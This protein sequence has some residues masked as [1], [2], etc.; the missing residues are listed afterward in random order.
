MLRLHGFLYSPP[1]RAC[2]TLS[3]ILKLDF[4]F[5]EVNAWKQENDA[6]T[7]R[8]LNPTGTIPVLQDGELTLTQSHTILR[9]LSTAYANGAWYAKNNPIEEAKVNAKLDW[10]LLRLRPSIAQLLR[11]DRIRGSSL[12]EPPSVSVQSLVGKAE[13]DSPQ[14]TLDEALSIMDTDLATS[15]FL[16]GSDPSIADLSAACEIEQVTLEHSGVVSR[17]ENI[18][19]WLKQIRTISEFAD[20]HADLPKQH[21]EIV[22]STEKGS[23][24]SRLRT[25]AID[26]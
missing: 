5:V 24:L 14:A 6:S 21:E 3:K 18:K 25:G 20:A 17:H 15:E 23:L 13:G 16:V 4:D 22:A 26:T 1:S 8:A 11:F 19:R 12:V 2:W 7:F 9:Y 10:Q